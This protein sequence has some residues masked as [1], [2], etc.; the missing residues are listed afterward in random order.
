MAS[1]YDVATGQM[2]NIPDKVTQ[3]ASGIAAD[4]MLV[5]I[6]EAMIAAHPDLAAVRDLYV[7]GD[8][9]GALNSLFSTDFYKNTGSA[10]LNN[11]EVKRNQ[12]G[13]YDDLIT[14]TWLPTLRNYATQNGLSINDANLKAIATKAYDMGLTPTAAGTLQLFKTTQDAAGNVIP[15]PYITGITGGQASTTR[16]NL[17][18][19]NADYGAGFNQDWITKASE[20]VATGATTEQYWTDQLKNQA[21]GAFPAWA[22]Q[23]KAGM[24]MKQI[25]SPYINAY[26]NILGIDSASVTLNDNLL[27]QGLQGTDPTKPGAMPL[28]EF[29]KAVR[30]DP[31]WATSKDA[32]DSLSSTGST[33][34]KQ[35]GLMS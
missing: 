17:Q 8:Y 31:R 18:T 34:L 23:I 27:K 30:Q 12:P 9:A 28:W 16:Q 7:G 4:P 26:S 35:W 24:T 20:S 21:S 32:M 22:D 3:P 10:K 19:L 6:T 11:E 29:E 33:I 13:V 1:K 14:N 15:N 5:G 2:I 25:A